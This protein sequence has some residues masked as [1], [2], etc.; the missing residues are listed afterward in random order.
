MPE[1]VGYG[2]QDQFTG[3]GKTL[4]VL[5][6]HIWGLSGQVQY[7]DNETTFIESETGKYYSDVF[8]QFS[9]LAYTADDPT[10]KVTFNGVLIVGSG[11]SHTSL[12]EL[13]NFPLRLLIPPLTVVKVTVT[14]QDSTP[15]Q[16]FVYIKGRIYK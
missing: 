7:D 16:G 8:I 10:I 4:N 12:S 6:N 9:T 11:H 1:G 14:N 2:P 13:N 5:G 15:I 3:A